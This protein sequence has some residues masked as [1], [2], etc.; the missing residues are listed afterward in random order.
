MS[1]FP[2]M[3]DNT[4]LRE[5]PQL[6]RDIFPLKTL[7]FIVHNNRIQAFGLPMEGSI[8]FIEPC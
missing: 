8:G 4:R 3:L 2:N 6:H 7:L 5:N 1:S